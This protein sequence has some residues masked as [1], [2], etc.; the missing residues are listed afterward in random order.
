MYILIGIW[1]ILR[2][3][4]YKVQEYLVSWIFCGE[5]FKNSPKSMKFINHT[6]KYKDIWIF[7]I[8]VIIKVQI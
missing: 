8:N 6:R 7:L 2:V 4:Q 1:I 3:T 5:C